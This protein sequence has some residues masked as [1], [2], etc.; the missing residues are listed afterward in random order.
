MGNPSGWKFTEPG[1]GRESVPEA[2]CCAN[3][4][5]R[6]G[7][8]ET[9]RTWR[10]NLVCAACH[11][12]LEPAR[13]APPRSTSRQDIAAGVSSGIMK[14]IILIGVLAIISALAEMLANHAL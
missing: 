8:L 1:D 3:C 6:I 13:G 14:I 9:P 12:R 4:H 10:G 5:Q 7:S 2:R 11:A